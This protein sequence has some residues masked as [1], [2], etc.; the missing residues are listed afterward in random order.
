M[1][2]TIF[3]F[4]VVKK[5]Y[6]R[7]KFTR[8]CNKTVKIFKCFFFPH[9]MIRVFRS[10]CIFVTRRGFKARPRHLKP[11]RSRASLS[12]AYSLPNWR[13]CASFEP[14]QPSARSGSPFGSWS[15][16]DGPSLSPGHAPPR[17]LCSQP[18][19]PACARHCTQ[20]TVSGSSMGK[21]RPHREAERAGAG[22]PFPVM[23]WMGGHGEASALTRNHYRHRPQHKHAGTRSMKAV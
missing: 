22:V 2:F 6:T 8:T 23:P 9:F 4:I 20:R 13:P 17:G 18:R 7:D 3:F 19:P 14:P 11:A 15:F 1:H 5:K 12:V 16:C 10:E 21:T